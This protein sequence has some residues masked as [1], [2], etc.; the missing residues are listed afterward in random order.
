MGH[1][2]EQRLVEQFVPHAT[3][4]ALDIAILHRPSGRDIMPLDADLAAPCQHGVAGELGSVVA[5]DHAGL[6]TLGDQLG[7]LANDTATRDRGIR[8]RCE[9]LPRHVIDD[10][11]HAEPPA[12]RHLIVNEVEAPALVR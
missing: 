8:H 11:E 3:V 4:E 5:D 7:Q 2:H 12:R 6:A 1:A 9:T 10:V